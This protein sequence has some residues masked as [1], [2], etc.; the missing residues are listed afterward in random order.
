M[1]DLKNHFIEELTIQQEVN[2]PYTIDDDGSAEEDN[3]FMPPIC[4]NDTDGESRE[5]EESMDNKPIFD[6][7]TITVGVSILLILTLAVRHSFTGEALNDI[8][9]LIN[10][11]CLSPNLCPKSLFQLISLVA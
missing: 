9:C 2:R 3:I 11:H 4:F 5:S 8:L 7:A 6:G 1:E 10:L